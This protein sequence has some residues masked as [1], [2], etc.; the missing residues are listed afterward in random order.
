MFHTSQHELSKLET[1][2]LSTLTLQAQIFSLGGSLNN[3]ISTYC[4]SDLRSDSY[5]RFRM[6]AMYT[7]F[8]HP[9]LIT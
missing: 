1:A 6:Y 5:A 8:P 2:P 9:S 4:T 7:H 3:I